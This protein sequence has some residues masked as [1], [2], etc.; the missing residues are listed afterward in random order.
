MRQLTYAIN[1][2]L[3]SYILPSSTWFS[4][5]ITKFTHWNIICGIYVR[6][7]A[8]SRGHLGLSN[9]ATFVGAWLTEHMSSPFKMV[10]GYNSFSGFWC[11][12]QKTFKRRCP[13]S[14]PTGMHLLAPFTRNGR[15]HFLVRHYPH[16]Q[17]QFEIV[18]EGT[19]AYRDL[20]NVTQTTP[21]RW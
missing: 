17:W 20:V 14:I 15:W 10:G 13:G 21:P 6:P 16:T 8:L 19:S 11:L 12:L 5:V 9:D 3:I 2:M 18:L 1:A 7:T 4:D